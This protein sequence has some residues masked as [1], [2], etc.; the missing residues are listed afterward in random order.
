[1]SVAEKSLRI[2]F[3]LVDEVPSKLG[4]IAG[5]TLRLNR[6]CDFTIQGGLFNDGS[7]LTTPGGTVYLEI[8]TTL[9]PSEAALF[10]DSVTPDATLT[11]V[12]NWDDLS[13]Q[14]FE[15]S[16]T[17][18]ETVGILGD[19]FLIVVWA[20]GGKDTT[21]VRRI[22]FAEDGFDNPTAALWVPDNYVLQSEVGTGLAFK[23][24]WD[25]SADSPDLSGLTPTAGDLYIVSVAGTDTLTG[26]SVDWL[27]GDRA[28]YNGSAW[29]RFTTSGQSPYA[30]ISAMAAESA[31]LTVN[32]T[33]TVVESGRGG[34]F[35]IEASG[36]ADNGIVF[37][38]ASGQYARR[39]Y[40]NALD[41]KWFGAT[42]DGSTDDTTAI[43]A[44]LDYATANKIG[45]YVP[46]GTYN[47]TSTLTIDAGIHFYGL[48]RESTII[49]QQTSGV[50]IVNLDGT[51][52]SMH[53]LTL[54]FASRETS[55]ADSVCFQWNQLRRSQFYDLKFSNGYYAM[56]TNQDGL[57]TYFIYSCS[58]D[59]VVMTNA[60]GA[61]IGITY[62]G[63][64]NTGCTFNNIYMNNSSVSQYD[65][66]NFINIQTCAEMQFTQINFE[67]ATLLGS[68]FYA[69]TGAYNISFRGVHVEGVDFGDDDLAFFAVRQTS[70]ARKFL[71]VQNLFVQTCAATVAN[72]VTSHASVFIIDDVYN[73]V[74]LKQAHFTSAVTTDA[75][76]GIRLL[77][78]TG[79]D[80][81][82]AALSAEGLYAGVVS[83]AN[84]YAPSTG[85]PVIRRVDDSIYYQDLQTPVCAAQ[86]IDIGKGGTLTP[87]LNSGYILNFDFAGGGAIGAIVGWTNDGSS[88][89]KVTLNSEAPA[90]SDYWNGYDLKFT[91]GV[92]SG[93]SDT[94]TDS[95]SDRSVLMGTSLADPT[96]GDT[97]E[98]IGRSITIDEPTY[99]TTPTIKDE[100]VV[101]FDNVGS[102]D[103]G[104][105]WDAVF[106]LASAYATSTAGTTVTIFFRFI[107]SEWVEV[108]RV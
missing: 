78:C 108:N 32:S 55:D 56:R 59:T 96:I 95:Y 81:D 62:E 84:S 50:A 72:G 19:L 102:A 53:G 85:V 61:F 38:L 23:G 46:P 89:L 15:I 39:I 107:N 11:D 2:A 54:Q 1:M 22:T 10:S 82:G 35:V 49:E 16:G 3:D 48:E 25:A 52:I 40:A 64:G 42:G 83:V 51:G 74:S 36:T 76:N 60:T 41:L 71:S 105:T 24:T 104:I 29:V 70:A 75:P 9:D 47:T 80:N 77:T 88:N 79:A 8:K 37:A 91:S 6:G 31:T 45:V 73:T 68:M 7:L 34:L 20:Y 27:V 4:D 26:S 92:N 69:G 99:Q 103:V 86:T 58:F 14:H 43:Q 18:A 93:S 101:Y 100:L 63:A 13:K 67:W 17:K 44:A 30:T 57:G 98:I 90:V 28:I 66:T 97:Y 21:W 12:A 5:N 94:I 65:I 33:V 87:D 106:S